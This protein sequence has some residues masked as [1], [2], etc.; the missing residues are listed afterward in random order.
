MGFAFLGLFDFP[1]PVQSLLRRWFGFS[2]GVNPRGYIG[3]VTAMTL[4]F[5]QG[6]VRR[7]SAA[8]LGRRAAWAVAAPRIPSATLPRARP[9]GRA[10]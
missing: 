1:G 10:A 7:Q 2:G 5:Y 3:V 9:G 8:T 4:V 6:G